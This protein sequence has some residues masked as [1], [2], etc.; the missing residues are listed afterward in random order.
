V[1]RALPASEILSQQMQF[2]TS[3]KSSNPNPEDTNG[4]NLGVAICTSKPARAESRER[5][6]PTVRSDVVAQLTVRHHDVLVI[7]SEFARKQDVG[8]YRY[9]RKIN[10]AHWRQG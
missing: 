4:Y 9:C 8:L 3:A 2:W 7:D 6:V 5:Q 10:S 1:A